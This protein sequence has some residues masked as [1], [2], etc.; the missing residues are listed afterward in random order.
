[1][2]AGPTAALFFSNLGS[3]AE[4]HSVRVPS[5]FRQELAVR[6]ISSELRFARR[7]I[8]FVSPARSLA[9]EI[10]LAVE[11]GGFASD[12]LAARSAPLDSRDAGLA[13]QIVLGVLR[14][15]AQLDYLIEHYSG[16][17]AGRLDLEVRLAL[18]M[19]IYQL[20]YLERVPAH[21]AVSESVQLV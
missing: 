7:Y 20:R 4:S 13:S 19:G 17:P 3:A 8:D 9:F 14:Y 12:L 6:A 2:L 21:A 18:R 16:K 5:K 1:V 15:R 11:R 10:L